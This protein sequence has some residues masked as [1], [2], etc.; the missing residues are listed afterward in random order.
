MKAEIDATTLPRVTLLIRQLAEFSADEVRRSGLVAVNDRTSR[1]LGSRIAAR[2]CRELGGAS[3]YVPKS[4]S[5]DRALRDQR[6]TTEH[7]GT[8][9]G[10]NGIHALARRYNLSSIAVWGIIRR[11][12]DR[13]RAQVTHTNLDHEETDQ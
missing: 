12:R 8:A 4:D 1:L 10:P 3:I 2:L 9:D 11:E 7:D 5:I 6:I 13:R